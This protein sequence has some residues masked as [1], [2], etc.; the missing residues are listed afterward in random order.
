MQW[1]SKTNVINYILACSANLWLIEQ[2]SVQDVFSH[3]YVSAIL[4][5]L[6]IT[7][8]VKTYYCLLFFVNISKWKYTKYVQY[9]YTNYAF[10]EKAKERP[11]VLDDEDVCEYTQSPYVTYTPGP[12]ERR[13]AICQR[14]GTSRSCL[15]PSRSS[16]TQGCICKLNALG[17]VNAFT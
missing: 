2:V 14:G 15:C 5:L 12:G 10:S 11:I 16:Q 9:A 4:R 6:M 3:G 8:S 1:C 13:Q 7:F 17:Q